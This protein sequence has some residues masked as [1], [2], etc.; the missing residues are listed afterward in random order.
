MTEKKT[1]LAEQ[2]AT[3]AI[4]YCGWDFVKGDWRISEKAL[5]LSSFFCCLEKKGK[6]RW[7]IEVI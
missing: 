4:S 7:W 6:L 3:S 2:A 1:N 5:V